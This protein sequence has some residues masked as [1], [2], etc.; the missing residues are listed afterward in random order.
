MTDDWPSQAQALTARKLLPPAD[1]QAVA[2]LWWFGRLIANA[3][4]HCGNLAL[5]C[6]S[7]PSPHF[8]L[9]PVCDMLPMAYA[10]LPGGEVP[11]A[12]W[13]PP[14]PLPPEAAVWQMACAVALAFWSQAATDGRVS[15]E[16]RR[17]CAGNV[18]RLERARELV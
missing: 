15:A 6:Q 5:F 12:K 13:E 10:P 8:Q 9:A 18:L 11:P 17:I 1:A 2:H 4:M 16:F 14:L 7:V 3:D